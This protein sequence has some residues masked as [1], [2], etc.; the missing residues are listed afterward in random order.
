MRNCANTRRSRD[1]LRL[2]DR[3]QRSARVVRRNRVDSLRDER[4]HWWP[5]GQH[6]VRFHPWTFGSRA[7]RISNAA[8][9]LSGR[10]VLPVARATTA[11]QH[12]VS[13]SRIERRLCRE[14]AVDRFSPRSITR[15][16][17]E[18]ANGVA[19]AASREHEDKLIRWTTMSTPGRSKLPTES[20]CL[21]ACQP[22]FAPISFRQI[23][24]PVFPTAAYIPYFSPTFPEILRILKM[25]RNLVDHFEAVRD[26]VKFSKKS[27]FFFFF[28]SFD[29]NSSLKC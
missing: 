25:P 24:S 6:L 17:N 29:L 27:I 7:E 8:V 13:A 19:R 14:L 15:R 11:T 12:F 21:C 4:V 1:R 18:V 22:G 2:R 23:D 28:V 26:S 20:L 10:A 3:R 16:K 9:S 5:R